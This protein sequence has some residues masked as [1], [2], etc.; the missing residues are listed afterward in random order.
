MVLDIE[1]IL[2]DERELGLAFEEISE[3]VVVLNQMKY[4]PH[5]DKYKGRIFSK[6]EGEKIMTAYLKKISN[7]K[8]TSNINKTRKQWKMYYSEIE[9]KVYSIK[10]SK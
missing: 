1:S 3:S 4:T 8:K 5:P 10:V 7:P 6:D 2:K 9:K